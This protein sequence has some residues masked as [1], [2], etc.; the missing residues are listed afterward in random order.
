MFSEPLQ[1]ICVWRAKAI[2]SKESGVV[3]TTL[4]A[5]D[6]EELLGGVQLAGKFSLHIKREIPKLL[7]ATF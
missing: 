1:I 2:N 5:G 3:K 6:I 4:E 7:M